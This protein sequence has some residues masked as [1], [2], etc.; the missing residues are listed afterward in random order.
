VVTY[1]DSTYD[2]VVAIPPGSGTPDSDPRWVVMASVGA[3]GQAGAPGATGP[4]GPMG[5]QGNPGP[6]GPQG[7]SGPQGLTGPQGPAA[8]THGYVAEGVAGADCSTLCTSNPTSSLNRGNYLVTASIV[9]KNLNLISDYELSCSL[10]SLNSGVVG[11]SPQI[12]V[13]GA[14]GQ[15]GIPASGSVTLI[16]NF[17]IASGLDDLWAQCTGGDPGVLFMTYVTVSAVSVGALD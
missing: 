11:A 1:N 2:A 13:P 14:F 10:Y 17:T 16:N 5:A 8:Q 6:A 4:A 9:V 15:V 7:L 3:T 12:R